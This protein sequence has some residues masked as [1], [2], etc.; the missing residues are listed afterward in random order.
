M[1]SSVRSV[2]P[3]RSGSSAIAIELQERRKQRLMGILGQGLP[4]LPN[5]VLDLNAL[6]SSSSVDL[7]KVSNVIRT[8]P[9]LSAQVLRLCNSALFGLR[10]RVLSIEQAAILLGTERL[11]TMVLT[12]SVMQFAGKRLPKDQLMAFWQHSFLSGLL[13]ER[14]ARQVDYFEKE[15]AYLGGLLHDIGQLPLWILVLQETAKQRALPPDGWVDNIAI[16]RDYFG[17]DHCKTGRMMAVSWNF[18]PSFIDV[19]E[20][21]HSPEQAQHDPYLV[22]LVA[23]ADQFLQTQAEHVAHQDE[24]GPEPE[25]AQPPEP[26]DPPFLRACLPSLAEPERLAVMEMLQTEYIHLLPLVQLGLASATSAAEP[27]RK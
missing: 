18:M 7:K 20:H 10:R 16:E 6:L 27:P 4:T 21:H 17:L 2:N 25:N 14:L 3:P 19:F 24:E 1:T 8:D 5:Y 9:S 12:C 22:G 23:A 13:S 26:L 15:Q 11:R